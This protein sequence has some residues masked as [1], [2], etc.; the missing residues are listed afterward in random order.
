MGKTP[1]D[2]LL[3]LPSIHYVLKAEQLCKQ[4]RLDHDL[5]PMPRRISSACGMALAFA[6]ADLETLGKLMSRAGLPSPR[7]FRR[8]EQGAFQVLDWSPD[9]G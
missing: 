4:Q 3:L 1:L 2:C 6:C 7:L 5:V 8:D 9:E